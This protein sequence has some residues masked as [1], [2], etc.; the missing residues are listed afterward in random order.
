MNTQPLDRYTKTI[1][2]IIALCLVWICIRDIR[3]VETLAAQVIDRGQEVVK[4][5]IVS[6]DE[7]P[8][9]AWEALPVTVR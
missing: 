9:L 1:L 2:T 5:Q 7:A 3:F 4:V 6:I 8:R